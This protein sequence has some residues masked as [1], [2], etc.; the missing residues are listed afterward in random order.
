M[1][2]IDDLQAARAI[3]L[4]HFQDYP[5]Q[6]YLFGSQAS[7]S[8]DPHSDIDIAILPLAPIP[9]HIFAAARAALEESN[10]LRQIDLVNLLEVAP[11]FRQSVLNTGIAWRP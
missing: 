11:D 3:V 5:V 2:R 1:N 4:T 8:A 10:I 7:G 6:I 9:A